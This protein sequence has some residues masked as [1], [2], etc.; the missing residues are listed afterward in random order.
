[1]KMNAEASFVRY[2][3]QMAKQQAL[4]DALGFLSPANLA[5]GALYEIAGADAIRYRQYRAQSDEFNRE[6]KAHFWPRMFTGG[7]FTSSDYN[8]IPRFSYHEE[9]LSNVVKRVAFS[10]CRTRPTHSRARLAG[11]RAYRRFPLAG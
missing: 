7:A 10:Y 5:Q 4:V 11:L 9:P 6:W 2:N 8:W 3:E 1:M